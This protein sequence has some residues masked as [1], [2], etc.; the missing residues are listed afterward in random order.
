M[1]NLSCIRIL[2]IE[3]ETGDAYLVKNALNQPT[4]VE[5]DITWVQSLAMAKEAL[6][7]ETFDVLLLDLS[8]PD[9]DGLETLKSARKMAEDLPIIVLTGRNDVEFALNALKFGAVDYIDKNIIKNGSDGLVRV[10]RYAL[11]RLELEENKQL[12][13]AANLNLDVLHTLNNAAIISETDLN[14]HL[15]FVNE[16]F[17]NISQYSEQALL[18]STHKKLSS[19]V[20]SKE[21]YLNLWRQIK[22]GQIWSGEICNRKKSGELYWIQTII[23]PVFRENTRHAHYKYAM[24][25]LDITE[26]KAREQAMENRAALYKAAIET[27]DGFCRISSSGQFLEVSDGYCK[28]SG[29]SREE[30]LS[31]NILKMHGDFGLTLQQFGL[32]IEGN[33]KTFEIEQRRK[34]GSV[35]IAEITASY[36]S[37]LEDRSLFIFLHD[38]TEKMNM[39][40]RDKILRDQITQMQKID[41]IGKLTAGICHDFNNILNGLLGYSDMNKTIVQED[42]PD[43]ELKKELLHNFACANTVGKRAAELIAKIMLYCRQNNENNEI[44]QVALKKSTA[45]VIQEAVDMVRVGFAD[46]FKIELAL[47]DTPSIYIDAI[48]LHQ[49]MTNL[50][51][52]A[53]DAMKEKGGTITVSLK[54]VNLLTYPCAA[55]LKPLEGEFI[56]LSVADNGSGIDQQIID[57]IFDSFFTTKKEG[58]GT[59]LGLSTVSAIVHHA[60]GHILMDSKLDVG[61]TFKLLFKKR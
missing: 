5:F 15:I 30:L 51:V 6:I 11:L 23:F 36:S 54:I 24:L 12:L 31:M 25:G 44:E 58:E 35:W 2:L 60:Q 55:C 29:Y 10:I 61:T 39:Q 48:D 49:I 13:A 34:N 17:C 26:R 32:I 4:V 41:S 43:S 50:L 40:K 16:Q 20:H 45:Q 27:T 59:G 52:N 56:E 47:H 14:G 22:N 28:L 33:G 57:K 19:G 18:G 53:R 9:S 21:F 37:A 8:L 46:N 38:I 7:V 3:D 1:L 42:L